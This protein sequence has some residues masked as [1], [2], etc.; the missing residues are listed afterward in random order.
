MVI[1]NLLST[2]QRRNQG[3]PRGMLQEYRHK[4]RRAYSDGASHHTR[5]VRQ[6]RRRYDQASQEAQAPRAEVIAIALGDL[7]RNVTDSGSNDR[8][9]LGPKSATTTRHPHRLG[10]CARAGVMLNLLPG[11]HEASPSVDPLVAR[12]H[13]PAHRDRRPVATVALDQCHR[14]LSPA[15]VPLL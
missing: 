8:S 7:R 6:S 12:L 15:R 2:P 1:G 11:E 13:P 10:I 5:Q 14:I 9:R 3:T 4:P